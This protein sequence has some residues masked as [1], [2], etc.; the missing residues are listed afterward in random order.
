MNWYRHYERTEPRKVKGGIKAKSKRGAFGTT[1]WGERWEETL[2]GF[3]I[4]NRL[5]RAKRYARK[6]QVLFVEIEEGQVRSEVQGSRSTPYE[7]TIRLQTY[8]DAEWNEIIETFRRQPYFAAALL[9]G[10][11][12]AGVEQ[13][14]ERAGVTL[15]PEREVDLTTDCSCPDWSNPCKHIAAVYLLLAEEFD[16]DPFLL[17]RLRGMEQGVLM[18]RIGGGD[19]AISNAERTDSPS[20]DDSASDAEPLQ[21]EGFWGG[22][23]PPNDVY[24][25][26]ETPSTHAALP[27]QLG[28]FPFWRAEEDLVGALESA[29]KAASAKGIELFEQEETFPDSS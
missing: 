26:V 21:A 24:G 22:S 5:Q 29:Y 23:D 10:D 27:K 8:D 12:P 13:V 1:W 7:V 15:F 2:K 6:G 4:T 9:A 3:G 25:S 28:K 11:M 14:V 16:R 18:D 20:A 17:F 19:A